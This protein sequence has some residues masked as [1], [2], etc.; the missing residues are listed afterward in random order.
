MPMDAGEGDEGVDDGEDDND[1]NNL[2]NQDQMD[3]V[4]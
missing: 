4:N 3:G 2:L 1:E